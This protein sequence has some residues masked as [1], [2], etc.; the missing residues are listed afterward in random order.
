MSIVLGVIAVFA[1]LTLVVAVVQARAMVRLAAQPGLA[2]FFPLGW[3]K[4]SAL[5]ARSGARAAAHVQVY[6][7]SV[8]AFIV[9]VV[10]GLVLSGW[11]ANSRAVSAGVAAL[12]FS[13]ASLPATGPG[14]LS[15]E[16]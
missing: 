13:L 2:S 7:R 10:L 4:F 16:P 3:W 15:L 9:F 12:S 5:E 8:V 14:A 11:A 1:V 6:K